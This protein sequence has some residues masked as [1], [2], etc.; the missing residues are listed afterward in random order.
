[1]DNGLRL[2][3]QRPDDR[4]NGKDCTETPHEQ[5]PLLQWRILCND[6]EG[7]A[8]YPASSD[9]LNRT[10]NDQSEGGRG[11]SANSTTNFENAKS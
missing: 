11:R 3:K 5:T 4:S 9:S 1:M 10:T 6:H 7:S 2:T 8:K